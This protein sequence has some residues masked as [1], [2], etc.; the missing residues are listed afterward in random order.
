MY[1]VW[2]GVTFWRVRKLS[3]YFE[4]PFYAPLLRPPDRPL[5]RGNVGQA[6]KETRPLGIRR[7]SRSADSND[8]VSL[9]KLDVRTEVGSMSRTLRAHQFRSRVRKFYRFG[10]LNEATST[11]LRLMN[12]YHLKLFFATVFSQ[13]TYNL[14]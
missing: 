12:F 9:E 2:R 1:L 7:R 14:E 6:V 11:S 5:E 4:S 13:M 3:S 10:K 8:K